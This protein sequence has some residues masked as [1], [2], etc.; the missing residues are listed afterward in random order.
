MVHQS[1][2]PTNNLLPVPSIHPF[3]PGLKNKNQKT[4]TKE[5][6]LLQKTTKPRHSY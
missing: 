2:D 1:I 5:K 3:L 6:K 4:N